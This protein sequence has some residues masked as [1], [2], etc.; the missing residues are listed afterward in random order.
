METVNNINPN[1]LSGF[2]TGEGCFFIKIKK[3][4]SHKLGYQ[5]SLIVKLSQ[6]ARDECLLKS[7]IGTKSKDFDDFCKV[8]NMMKEG[9]HLTVEGLDQIRKIKAGMNTGRT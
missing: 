7:F 5:V 9:K 6:H 8:A 1:W 3:S 2:F 4:K